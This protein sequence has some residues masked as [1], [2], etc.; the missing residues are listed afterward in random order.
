MKKYLLLPLL[1]LA[2]ILDAQVT[3]DTLRYDGLFSDREFNIGDSLVGYKMTDKQ[4]WGYHKR[5]W[6]TPIPNLFN[7][8]LEI[9]SFAFRK[10]TIWPWVGIV[11]SSALLYYY[12]KEILDAGKQ[13]GSWLGIAGDDQRRINLS[14]SK[15]LAVYI[16]GDLGYAMYYIGDG[17]LHLSINAAF[18]TYGYG[19]ADQRAIS[20][21]QQLT[22][23]LGAT[24]IVIQLLKRTTGRQSPFVV[25][26]GEPKRG[27]W[28]PFPSFS[29][30][31]SS[32][33]Q[34][35]AFPS[36]HLA[37]AMM[38]VTVL[39]ENY[40]EYEWIRP[41]GYSLMG[42][43]AFQML[44]NGVHWASDYPLALGIGYTIGK[45][46]VIR[47]RYRVLSTKGRDNQSLVS[48]L[49]NRTI[50]APIPMREG[51]GLGLSYSF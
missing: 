1:F 40:S 38:T 12:D 15:E 18:Y 6:Y 25:A 51:L 20:T 46:A 2:N 10:E 36:G 3:E 47:A 21:A 24:G 19:W 37:T 17:W 30:Y 13:L 23:G 29:T 48:N 14:S 28:R 44:N 4:A 32:V 11:T 8:L 7:N 35:D 31:N 50:I 16:P 34:Y 9:P 45:L 41:V 33:P 27:K 43:L 42:L 49:L 26:E 39:A 5:A 22:E